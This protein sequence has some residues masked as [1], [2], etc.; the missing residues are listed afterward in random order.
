MTNE[1]TFLISLGQSLATMALY[2]E[3]HPARE[4]AIEA[5]F[6]N[7]MVL[8]ADRPSIKFS[9]LGNEAVFGD[10]ALTELGEWDW[11]GKLSAVGIERIEI[12]AEV[13]HDAYLRFVDDVWQHISPQGPDTSE[14]RQ[15]VRPPIRFGRLR[16]RGEKA[17]PGQ[18]ARPGVDGGGLGSSNLVLTEEIETIDWV[19]QEIQRQA[20]IPLA[21]VEAV[22]RSLAAAMRTERKM[23]LPLLTL[24]QFDQYTTTHACNV[25]VL[26]MGL[27]ER[28]GLTADEVRSF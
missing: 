3:G 2:G 28:L 12:D 19:H 17:A 1:G 15:M 9:F 16:V 24:K 13:T 27:S 6:E 22:V 21:E 25:A 8:T 10:R 11:A 7:L 5:S 18:E 26:A 23:L 20:P 14:A 4:R